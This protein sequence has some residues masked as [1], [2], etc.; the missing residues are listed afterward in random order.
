MS[1]SLSGAPTFGSSGRKK[2]TNS[3]TDWDSQ[4]QSLLDAPVPKSVKDNNKKKNASKKKNG[5]GASSSAGDLLGLEDSADINA[6]GADISLEE[7]MGSKSSM[8]K[9]RASSA[10]GGNSVG[11]GGSSNSVA[12][13]HS[14]A[15][16]ASFDAGKLS[17]LSRIHEANKSNLPSDSD[18]DSDDDSGVG[19]RGSKNA[20]SRG[21]SPRTTPGNLGG[22]GN[23]S[24]DK[25]VNQLRSEKEALIRAHATEIAEIK[26]GSRRSVKEASTASEDIARL[27]GELED[28]RS[29]LRTQEEKRIR[30]EGELA[31]KDLKSTEERTLAQAQFNESSG[32]SRRKYDN[33]AR[34]L[35]ESHQ[36][37]I[38]EL[39]RSHIEEIASVRQRGA[40]AQL[41]ESLSTQ[42]KQT[43]GTL[44]ILENQ[45]IT[46]KMASEAGRESQMEARERLLG[47][48][49]KNAKESMERSESQAARLQGSVGSIEDV[50][51]A[52]RNQ[53][54]EERE[55][56][57]GEHKRLESLQE[58]LMTERKM[59]LEANQEERSKIAD[60]WAAFEVEKRK[61]EEDLSIRREEI[62]RGRAALERERAEFSRL[63]AE[64]SR[65]AEA[66]VEDMGMEEKRLGEARQML[67][68]DVSVFEQRQEAAKAEIMNAEQTRLDI[69]KVR[70]KLD[71]DS[72]RFQDMQEELHRLAQQVHEKG[73]EA[74]SKMGEAERIRMEG[75]AAQKQALAAKQSLDVE[76]LRI[77]EERRKAD[78][79][80]V[81]IAH[82]KMAL[83]REQT[84]NRQLNM[85]LNSAVSVNKTEG[86]RMAW[87]TVGGTRGGGLGSFGGGSGINNDPRNVEG[88]NREFLA[89][90]R[91]QVDELRV[92]EMRVGVEEVSEWAQKEDDFMNRVRRMEN[93]EGREGGLE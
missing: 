58:S 71:E 5:V 18:S 56:L 75:L 9:V 10:I 40:D 28:T 14:S 29:K 74:E 11:F 48:M 52:L 66:Q 65:A 60:R 16:M 72:L 37:A 30:L 83:L 81:A 76:K 92:G 63:Q 53:N 78:D 31:A 67:I 69:D 23:T 25:Q 68:R 6:G 44:K 57:K 79:E 42:I 34:A 8:G 41:L 1:S 17:A 13:R 64:A 84:N 20:G 33:E 46:S 54:I 38:A 82:E 70:A 4:M 43:A 24:L 19:S 51:R 39:K 80:R 15:N 89:G 26:A 45:M 22:R 47:E 90:L 3:S 36:R 2:S 93:R 62:D 73:A 49:E 12:R 87:A 86:G 88:Y 59:F 27:K 35:A 77:A 7:S 61:M 85:K 91:K 50:M 21:V 55:R 32:E